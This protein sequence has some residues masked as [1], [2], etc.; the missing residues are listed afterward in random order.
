MP[1]ATIGEAGGEELGS[2]VADSVDGL[3]GDEHGHDGGFARAGGE[4]QGDAVEAGVGFSIGVGEVFEDAFGGGAS[5]G[6]FGEPDSGFGGFD[7]AEKGLEIGEL[8]VTPVLKEAGCG[9]GDA[10]LCGIGQSAPGIDL[11][12][13]FRGCKALG[14]RRRRI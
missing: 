14:R 10:P 1:G 11:L 2:G 12:N 6:D 9:R 13:G 3:P 8:V 7:L 5:G 4:F